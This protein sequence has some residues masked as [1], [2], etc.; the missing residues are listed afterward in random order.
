MSTTIINFFSEAQYEEVVRETEGFLKR[1][2]A[3]PTAVHLKAQAH[4]QLGEYEAC[5]RLLERAIVYLVGREPLETRLSLASLLANAMLEQGRY[6]EVR[7]LVAHSVPEEST[8][9]EEYGELLLA[10]AWA[11]HFEGLFHLADRATT[12]IFEISGE[13]F[14]NGRAALCAAL[15]ARREGELHRGKAYL[16]KA[17]HH[18]SQAENLFGN[19]RAVCSVYILQAQIARRGSGDSFAAV[20][21]ELAALPKGSK[22]ATL[23]REA[24]DLYAR[25]VAKEPVAAA[26][27]EAVLNG[28]KRTWMALLPGAQARP[29]PTVDEPEELAAPLASEAQPFDPQASAEAPWA[30]V[31][32]SEAENDAPPAASAPP[33]EESAKAAPPVAASAKPMSPAETEAGAMP[34]AAIEPASG[35]SAP[36][37]GATVGLAGEERTSEDLPVLE[38]ALP[39]DATPAPTVGSPASPA[40][41]EVTPEKDAPAEDEAGLARSRPPAEELKV[42]PNLAA[43]PDLDQLFAPAPAPALPAPPVTPPQPPAAETRIADGIAAAKAAAAE[44]GSRSVPRA[45]ASAKPAEGAA[46]AKAPP[47]AEGRKPS[48]APPSGG[49]SADVPVLVPVPGPKRSPTA[50]KPTEPLPIAAPVVDALSG[51]RVIEQRLRKLQVRTE[52]DSTLLRRSK[53]P[54]GTILLVE[55]NDGVARGFGEAI[56]DTT[57]KVAA[58]SLTV[59]DALEK[60]VLMRPTLVVV[61]LAAPGVTGVGPPG[62]PAFVRMFLELDPHCKIAVISS[63]ATK[64]MVMDAFRHG[65]RTNVEAPFDRHKVL[66]ALTKAVTARSAVEALRIPTLELRRPIACSWKPVEKDSLKG[67]LSNWQ[68]FVARSLDPMGLEANLPAA[69]RVGTMVRLNIEIPGGEKA[70]Q[71]LAEVTSCKHEPALKH[72]VVRFSY[73]KLP[74]EARDRLVAFLMESLS[75]G[76]KGRSQ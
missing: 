51:E 37:A 42:L 68:S 57:F 72:H 24:V 58:R 39:A 18:L 54:P 12:R 26:V 35:E 59:E 10:S 31:R 66:D 22:I 28:V 21:V 46:P 6:E 19:P 62:I 64:S 20:R 45:V 55:P 9:R 67:L 53:T 7:D 8:A 63:A 13:H 76:T 15:T 34:V 48:A 29:H 3:N 38:E 43:S 50:K 23:L 74:T 69:S 56:K 16:V 32:V 52:A 70:I 60:Y 11:A 2:P 25:F 17:V 65:A 47:A 49:A 1:V 61:D 41:G 30:E 4:Y 75:K 5:I 33:V 36:V 44:P 14:T 71:T 73:V 40:A 27:S